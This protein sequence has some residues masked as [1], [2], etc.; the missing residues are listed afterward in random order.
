[1]TVGGKDG[2]EGQPRRVQPVRGKEAHER[3]QLAAPSSRGHA[4]W[5]RAATDTSQL[6]KGFAGAA[7][8]TY[9]VCKTASQQRTKEDGSTKD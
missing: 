7:N 9:R 2:I 1:M 8:C 5:Y 4:A 3:R 6:N